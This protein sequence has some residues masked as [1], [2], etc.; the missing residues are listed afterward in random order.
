MKKQY[1]IIKPSDFLFPIE[2]IIDWYK[3]SSKKNLIIALNGDLGAGKTTFTQELGR[4]LKVGDN[5]NSPT[6]TIMKQY[7][8]FGPEFDHFI[9]IDAYRIE[10]EEEILPLHIKEILTEPKA[11]VC[12]EWPEHISSVI[13][14]D[15]IFISLVIEKEENRQMEVDFN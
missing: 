10:S 12:V 2:D 8:I 7:K 11:V 3:K 15:A 5:I 1:S 6:F 14:K 9:H 13:P 4:F